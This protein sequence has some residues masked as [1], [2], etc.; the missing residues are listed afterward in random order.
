MKRES[1]VLLFAVG[2]IFLGWPIISIFDYNLSK[3]L[4]LAWFIFI[5]LIFIATT[6]NKK[7]NSGG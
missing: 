2:A 7:G 6:Y 3:Y 4:F 5:V 1:W